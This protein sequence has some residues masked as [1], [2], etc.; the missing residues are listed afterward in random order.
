MVLRYWH[1]IRG[2][3]VLK[4]FLRTQILMIEVTLYLFF[5]LELSLNFAVSLN[6]ENDFEGN[7]CS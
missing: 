7:K 6:S 2:K 3:F 5:F 4:L 1:L